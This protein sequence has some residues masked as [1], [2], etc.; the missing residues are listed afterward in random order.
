MSAGFS[1]GFTAGSPARQH[2]GFH[3][4]ERQAQA[5]AGVHSSSAGIRAAMPMQHRD[6]FA[7]LRYVF[8]ATLDAD[9]QPRAQAWSG[10]PGFID[11]PGANSLLIKVPAQ[12]ALSLH[13]GEPIGLLGLDLGNRRRNRA[14][15]VVRGTDQGALLVDV[16]ESF[17]NCPQ[18]ITLRDVR[19]APAGPAAARSFEGLQEAALVAGA[20]TFF[21]ATSGGVHG[22]DISHRGGPPGFVGI[23]GDTLTVPDFNG[24]RYFNTLGNLLLE[25][26]AALLFV[27]FEKGDVLELL[28]SV[29]I[30]WSG[31][32]AVPGQAGGR[33]WRFTVARGTLHKGALGLRWTRRG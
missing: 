20:D 4:G 26:R 13:P 19:E 27:D 15:G 7:G 32:P 25:P 16:R 22:V 5:L 21:I 10:A 18:Y 30:D 31:V 1:E 14:N 33:G 29:E 3:P 23:A 8:A 6:F 9:G 24:N 28:G 17:G 11:S 2:P 12:A